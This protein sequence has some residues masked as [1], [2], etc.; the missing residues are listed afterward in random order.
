M[1][2]H[3]W[4]RSKKKKEGD[5][6]TS[7]VKRRKLGTLYAIVEDDKVGIGITMCNYKAGDQWNKIDGTKT[8][9]F[10][11]V[12]AE[13]RARKHIDTE[14]IKIHGITTIPQE[15]RDEGDGKNIWIKEVKIPASALASL[16]VFIE[17]CRRYYKDKTLPPWVDL[18]MN[19]QL[20]TD[21]MDEVRTRQVLANMSVCSM[22][23]CFDDDIMVNVAGDVH[24]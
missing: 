5:K 24:I 18:V 22:G 17:R 12:V 20:I 6:T 11:L 21:L 8:K 15:L 19:E 3:I 9:N 7:P 13:K 23:D 1:I 10:N 2:Q 16:R 14:W 4:N